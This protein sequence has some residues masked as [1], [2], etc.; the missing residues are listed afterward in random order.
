MSK[1]F[2]DQNWRT[3]VPH[4]VC[5]AHPE[6]NELYYRAWELAYAHIKTLSG[7][8]QDPYMDEA[9]CATQ[10]WIW[11]SCFMSLFCKYAGEVFPGVE[12]LDNFYGVL[13]EGRYLP[14]V[15]P[16]KDEPSW[17]WAVYG[18]PYEIKI[19]LADNPP[20]FAW[21]EYENLLISGDVERVRRLLT[22]RCVLQKHY[23][24]LENLHASTQ[25][26]GVCYPTQWMAEA[27]GSGY[28]WEGGC[29][30][31]DNTPRGRTEE[32]AKRARPN[33]PEM[34]WIDA[35]CQ[36]A[37]SARMLARLFDAIGETETAAQWRTRYEKKK[38]TVNAL[39]WDDVDRFYYDIDRH[40]HDFYR[41]KSIASYWTLTAGI[42]S[43][44]RAE[45]LARLLED[46]ETFGGT[47]P[48]PSVA[49][50]DNDYVPCGNYWR[51]SVWLPTAYAALRGLNNYGMHGVAHRT[52]S[53]L[54]EHMAHTYAACE[55][56]TIW[57]CYHP[58]Q[59]KPGVV[60]EGTKLVRPDFCGWSAL[61]P[62]SIYLEQV[63]GFHTVDALQK[64]IEWEKPTDLAG[65]IGVRNL[66]FGTIVTDIVA[67]DAHCHVHANG[68]YT[69]VICGKAYA[70]QQ[71]DNEL[72]LS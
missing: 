50:S 58:E 15:M 28:R 44:E 45:A 31:M 32:H 51:G 17:T 26:T 62:I 21:A 2:G 47:V 33:N 11:D 7:M 38:E 68:A 27:D 30:G 18:E 57:E 36:Q 35:I 52:A 53:V 41:V 4:P 8:P 19:H 61:G 48:F 49:R 5:D 3:H 25:P 6:W 65:Q 39:Y 71:G 63:L 16:P 46:A 55:P 9:F 37:L 20:L 14:A 43:S 59:A 56:H 67:T 42:A 22:E 54:L 72:T 24:W 60:A 34:L 40:S 70:I 12:T 69:L 10:V 23:M 64:R 13:H 1:H 29:S 66:R